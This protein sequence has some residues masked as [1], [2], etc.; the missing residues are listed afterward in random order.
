M[1]LAVIIPAA[2]VGKRFSTA[3]GPGGTSKTEMD[4]AGQPV[5]MRS[6]ELFLKRNGVEQIIVAVN[7]D[8][9][10]DFKFRWGDKLG[11]HGVK[12]VAGGKKERWE[13]VAKALEAVDD[14][15]THVAVHDAVRPLASSEMIDRVFEAARTYPAVIPA[16][17]VNGTLKLVADCDAS[18]TGQADP[19]DAILGSA[20]KSRVS[21][22]R[23][24][25]TVDRAGV[26]EVQTPQVFTKDL[27]QKA[28]AQLVDGKVDL[29]SITDD[30][31]LVQAMG[32][33]V[34]VVD[35][36]VTNL[37]ITRAQDLELAAVILE[38]CQLRATAAMGKKRL[39]N[40]DEDE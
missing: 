36:E 15:C 19:L 10:S 24:V 39:F 14:R 3:V 33:A 37:K 29:A 13:T 40:L 25:K 23:V 26:V 7:P 5:F 12:V 8:H 20:G 28:Y 30:A 1:K 2:G 17:P 9:V 18:D 34:Y 11:F 21:V 4:L 35:G 22:K 27:L 6:V 38:K 16:V 32:Q 31:G